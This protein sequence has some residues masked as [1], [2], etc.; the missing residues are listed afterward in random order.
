[1]RVWYVVLDNFPQQANLEMSTLLTVFAAVLFT[2]VIVS[3]PWKADAA[4]G[5]T[6]AITPGKLTRISLPHGGMTR[7]YLIYVPQSAGRSTNTQ[8]PLFLIYHGTPSDAELMAGYTNNQVLAE[9]KNYIVVFPDG[10]Q[11]S[12]N[13][14]GCC[15]PA[16]TN[17]IDD[18][19]FTLAILAD[20]QEKLCV[21]T[22]QTFAAGWSNGGYMA[23][24]LGCQAYDSFDAIMS[25]GGLI[26]IDPD[27]ECHI[28][29]AQVPRYLSMHET[30]DPYVNYQGGG[31]E[32]AGA[33]ELAALWAAKAGCSRETVSGFCHS[34]APHPV[35]C[36]N[37]TGCPNHQ[38]V[39][40]CKIIDDKHT[41]P[42]GIS[43]DPNEQGTRNVDTNNFI[44]E[45]FMGPYLPTNAEHLPLWQSDADPTITTGSSQKQCPENPSSFSFPPYRAGPIS[46]AVFGIALAMTR[47][48]WTIV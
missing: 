3:G 42:G 28:P 31:D 44:Y 37:Y 7:S 39:V 47:T 20:V 13:A 26:G 11:N 35:T 36:R 15:P 22:T 48:L 45:F 18:V 38:D 12:W 34:V 33:E 6:P 29:V 9:Q 43:D 17:N 21:N 32:Y 4:C 2:A 41:W 23:L 16:N 24:L 30:G 19:G 27:T 40:Q 8:L 10:Y 14:G 25:M 1:M 5:T 46:S